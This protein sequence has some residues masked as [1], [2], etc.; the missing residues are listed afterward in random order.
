MDSNTIREL[1]RIQSR[2]DIGGLEADE[3]AEHLSTVIWLL[4]NSLSKDD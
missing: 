2:L 1:E 4:I 3:V